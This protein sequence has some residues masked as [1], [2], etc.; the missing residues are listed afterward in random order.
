MSLP[1]SNRILLLRKLS[2]VS[3]AAPSLVLI[4]L[5]STYALHPSLILVVP[6]Q[7]SMLR[8]LRRLQPLVEQQSSCRLRQAMPLY[9]LVVKCLEIIG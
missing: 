3:L 9:L 6:S 1:V 4:A 2:L 7:V 8:Y 5:S